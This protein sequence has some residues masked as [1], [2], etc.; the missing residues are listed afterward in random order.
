[1]APVLA[2][3]AGHSATLTVADVHAFAPSVA[4]GVGAAASIAL[5]RT[6]LDARRAAAPGVIGFLAL[7]L[8]LGAGDFTAAGLVLMISGCAWLALAVLEWRPG[9]WL[10]AG[11]LSVGMAMIMGGQGVAVI[12]AYTAVPALTA[13]GIGLWWMYEEPRVHS[14]QALGAG[15]AL[16]LV[17]SY[18]ALLVDPDS[19]LRT[20]ILTALTIALAL[21]GVFLQWFAPILATAV[22]AVTVSAAQLVVGSNMIVRLVSFAV[23]GSILLAIATLFER[24]KKL[25]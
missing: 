5:V 13:L 15:L 23:V 21:V 17:P 2:A 16:A 6:G 4:M 20:I 3:L 11:A 25:R 12:E 24:L 1:M 8:T 22:T 19:L 10:S 18:I 14:L 9:R 7:V